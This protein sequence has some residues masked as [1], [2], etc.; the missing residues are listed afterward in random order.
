MNEK[1]YYSILGVDKTASQ[2]E[3]KKA[4]RK[5][6]K[7]W[8]PDRNPGDKEAEEKFKE[9]TEAYDCLGDEQKRAQYDNPNPFSDNGGFGSFGF[10]GFNFGAFGFDGFSPEQQQEPIINGDNIYVNLNID[11]SDLYNLGTKDISYIRKKKC[12]VCGGNGEK[13]TCEYCN[14]TGMIH[15]NSMQGNVFYQRVKPCTH[16][17]GTGINYIIHCDHCNN[18]GLETE[19]VK[20][21]VDI[22]TL[23]P[24]I[25]KHGIKINAG[26][27]GSDSID[28]KG[29]CG[30][31][32][33]IINHTFDTN[34]WGIENNNLV[35]KLNINIFEM[36]NGCTKTITLPNNKKIS[37]KIKECTK[38]NT[39]LN[40]PNYGLQK[41]DLTNRNGL[42]IRVVPIYP[43]K[44]TDKQKELL[45]NIIKE[46]I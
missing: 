20:K 31:L 39:L 4:Y 22:K 18:T 21:T 42:N 19:I 26:K 35:Y 6:S 27:Y 29:Q 2:D 7:K 24:Y 28:P 34:I 17:N 30:N 5:L 37:I 46:E 38:P 14:G 9:I 8:H 44:L 15:E 32:Y 25:L 41:Y 43:T 36:L 11:I 33:Y 13:H 23:Y 3:I 40:V 16:C 45:N 12:S 1:D 10:N